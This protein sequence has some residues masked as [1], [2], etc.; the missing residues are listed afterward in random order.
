MD[1]VAMIA[2]KC[3][4]EVHLQPRANRLGRL[5]IQSNGYDYVWC[6]WLCIRDA[7]VTLLCDYDA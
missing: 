5:C 2:P 3:V 7:W 6:M 1:G 4:D